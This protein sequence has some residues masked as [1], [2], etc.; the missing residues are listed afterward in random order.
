MFGFAEDVVYL[1]K[2]S[3]VAF[4]EA[5]LIWDEDVGVGSA[6]PAGEDAF[7]EE[8]GVE[9]LFLR[10]DGEDGRSSAAVADGDLVAS[11]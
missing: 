5:F 1:G 3:E 9:A 6:D 10:K 11:F 8:V 4:W 7:H 2:A